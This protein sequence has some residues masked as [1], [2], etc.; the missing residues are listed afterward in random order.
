MR[1]MSEENTINQEMLEIIKALSAK[2]EGL[3]RAVYNKDN[4]LMKSGFV[5]AETP[6][7]TIDNMGTSSSVNVDSMNWSDIHKMVEKAGGQ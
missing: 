4:L 3:E 5:V 1:K 2:I 7:P 6:T